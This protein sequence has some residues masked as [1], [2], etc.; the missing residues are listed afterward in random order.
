MKPR[1]N[2]CFTTTNEAATIGRVQ[3]ASLTV[4]LL[5]LKYRIDEKPDMYVCYK[6]Q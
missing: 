6:D 5:E 4:S 3:W 1:N 2:S